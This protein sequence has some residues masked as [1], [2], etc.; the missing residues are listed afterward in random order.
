MGAH[1]NTGVLLMLADVAR[2]A[3]GSN[4]RRTLVRRTAE[5][6]RRHLP[7]TSF[8]LGNLSSLAVTITFENEGR[9]RESLHDSR[10]TV[11]P[12]IL[13]TGKAASLRGPSGELVV[14]L[15]LICPEDDTGYVN[16]ALDHTAKE[17]FL[18]PPVLEALGQI[19]SLAHR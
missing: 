4:T 7:V 12:T 13:R 5:A 11:S 19:L 17:A 6:L 15:P 10:I 2:A 1:P 16:I 18:E 3:T 9:V 8:E 14:L